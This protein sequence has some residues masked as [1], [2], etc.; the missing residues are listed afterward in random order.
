LQLVLPLRVVLGKSGSGCIRFDMHQVFGLRNYRMIPP[1]L[2]VGFIA[3]TASLDW[4]RRQAKSDDSNKIY[5]PMKFLH[6]F[7]LLSL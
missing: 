4:W 3:S 5:F 7:N 6:R 1:D 2:P